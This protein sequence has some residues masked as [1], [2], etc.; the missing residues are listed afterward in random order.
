MLEKEFER[1]YYKFRENFCRNLFECVKDGSINPSDLYCLE[2]IFLLGKPKVKE[3]AEKVNISLP[4]ASYRINNLI[5]KGYLRKVASKQDRREYHLEVTDKFLCS[6]GP[7]AS[8]NV[9]LMSRIREKFS[10]EEIGV[11]ER[12]IRKIVDEIME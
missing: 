2:V 5:E 3:F 1:L 8:F 11:L 7:N 9:R 12:M 4:N 10:K 6:Y